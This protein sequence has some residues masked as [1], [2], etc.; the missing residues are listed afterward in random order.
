[1][2]TEFKFNLDIANEEQKNGIKKIEALNI[3]VEEKVNLILV[4]LGVKKGADLVVY[5]WGDSPKKIRETIIN[6]SK[7]KL[8]ESQRERHGVN[9]V[10]V[11]EVALDQQVADRLACLDPSKDH[12]E[13]GELMGF[14]QTAVDAFKKRENLLKQE[15]YPDMSEI[16]VNFKFSKDNWQEEIRVLKYWSQLIKKYAPDLYLTLQEIR[17]RKE[18]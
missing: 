14:P 4:L 1:M 8:T 5:R 17:N 18:Y 7:L 2:D 13:F 11:Y 3:G 9:T 12:K 10:A 16:V 6:E 15:N